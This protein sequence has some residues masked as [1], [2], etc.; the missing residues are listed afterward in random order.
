M[1]TTHILIDV[2]S[3]LRGDPDFEKYRVWSQSDFEVRS[4][5]RKNIDQDILEDS[6]GEKA[7]RNLTAFCDFFTGRLEMFSKTSQYLRTYVLKALIQDVAEKS[8]D[9]F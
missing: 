5:L 2:H 8:Q 7:L 3:R 1:M 4:V 9:V 6:F